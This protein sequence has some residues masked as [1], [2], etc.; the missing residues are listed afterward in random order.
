MICLHQVDSW[1]AAAQVHLYP[2]VRSSALVP[3]SQQTAPSVQAE[4][5]LPEI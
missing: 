1:S 3:V 4:R 5:A 2:G